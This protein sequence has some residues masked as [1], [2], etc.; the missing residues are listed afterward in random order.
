M[1]RPVLLVATSIVWLLS[2]FCP[3]ELYSSPVIEAVPSA[4]K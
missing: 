3:S 4:E 1:F 2:I